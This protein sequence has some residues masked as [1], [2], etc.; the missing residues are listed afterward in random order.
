MKI[1]LI[2]LAAGN[3]RR[4]NGNK[5]LYKIDGQ[6]M[7]KHILNK[8]I[9]IN[10]NKIVLVT[11]Y[12]KIKTEVLDDRVLIGKVQ[13]K[14]DIIINKQSELGISESIK[15]GINNDKN[16]D[17]YMFMVCDQPFIEKNTIELLI[18]A[19]KDTDK[20]IACVG[21]KGIL[22]NPVIFSRK[23]LKDLISLT[24]DVGGKKI[25]NK[26]LDDVFTMNIFNEIEV[27]D[28]DTQEEV[29]NI[30]KIN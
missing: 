25:V 20:G 21:Y 14:L 30:G 16:A 27:Y 3:S 5:L 17:A 4:F 15:L 28:I 6:P 8:V 1:N 9:D 23:Y 19:F 13:N 2:L 26:N 7:Y 10:F 22:F 18:Q 24:K 12:E 11:Q 29:N